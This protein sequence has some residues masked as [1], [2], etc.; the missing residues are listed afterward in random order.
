MFLEDAVQQLSLGSVCQ[1][2]VHV[3]QHHV[4]T[5]LGR[6]K[7]KKKQQLLND[8]KHSPWTSMGLCFLCFV[9]A[10]FKSVVNTKRISAM[11]NILCD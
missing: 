6:E 11:V 8:I 7:Q 3:C 10:P 1:N 9:V 4:L 2:V 5:R